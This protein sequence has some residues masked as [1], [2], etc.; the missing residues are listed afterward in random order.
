MT[1]ATLEKIHELL[2]DEVKTRQTS[3]DIIQKAYYEKERILEDLARDGYDKSQAPVISA[4]KE[5]DTAKAV[6]DEARPK[7]YEADTALR[8]FEAQEF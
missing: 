3:R 7:L 4:T 1:I 2:K 6:Y 5:K 8:D